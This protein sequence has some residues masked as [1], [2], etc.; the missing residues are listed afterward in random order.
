ME[1]EDGVRKLTECDGPETLLGGGSGACTS[2]PQHN[3]I[4]RET[5]ESL[6]VQGSRW[7]CLRQHTLRL[8]QQQLQHQ[9]QLQ[10]RQQLR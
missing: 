7:A 8:R 1:D 6:R 9:Q 10:L 2:Y 4:A 5:S 3:L